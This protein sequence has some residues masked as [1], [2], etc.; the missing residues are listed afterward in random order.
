[1]LNVDLHCHSNVSDGLLSPEQIAI[2][3][4]NN[5]IDLWALTDHDEI[6]G[7]SIAHLTA[8]DLGLRCV[9]GVEIS[10]TWA[11]KT[12]HILGL[13]IDI[14][15][16]ELIQGLEAI[17]KIRE[18]RA[19]EIA[20][21]LNAVGIPNA[22]EG[23]LKYV[24]NRNLISRTH[25]ARY[26]VEIGYGINTKEVFRRYLH[27]G[28]PAY[29]PCCWVTLQEV[30]N[31]IHHANG[32]AVIAHPGRYRY[33]ELEFSMLFDE[34]K[35]HGGVG[36]EVI[37]GS[38]TPKQYQKYAKIAKYYGFLASIG[39]D[40]HSPCESYLDLGKVPELPSNLKPIWYNWD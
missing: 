32:V 23:A 7:I 19:H 4:K 25:F 36:I 1:M 11:K 9:T 27:H 26:L 21:Q 20:V 37:T 40:F 10:V 5:N 13:H 8:L 6:S 16:V 34:F 39:S 12:I 35:Q 24:Y 28:K 14:T 17:R 22:F 29:V 33:T 15:N 18:E 3:A 31:W 2:R 30:I 38:H